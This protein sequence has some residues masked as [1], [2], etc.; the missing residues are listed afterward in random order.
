M[1]VCKL[2]RLG[3]ALLLG[4][5]LSGCAQSIERWIVATR[6]NQGDAELARGNVRDA[7]LS[8]QLALKVNPDDPHARAGFVNASGLL[9][10]VEYTRGDFDDALANIEEGLH[11]DPG[12]VRLQALKTAI[13]E[14]RLKR[15]IVLSNYPTYEA[16]GAQIE[17]AYVQLDV[18]NK[19]ILAAMKR[20]AYTFDT[21]S[22]TDAVKRSY[23]LELEIAHNTNRLIAYRQL[24]SSGVP[25]TTRA[26]TST[27]ASSLLP[28]P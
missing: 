8:Y 13:D 10:H 1:S 27:G 20:F 26:A 16:A 14:A 11:Y 28:L 24:V 6:V 25:E 15:D 23:E 19:E 17:T 3:A 9:A 2:L 4:V 22:L 18:A 5:A 21:D 12:S 7:E